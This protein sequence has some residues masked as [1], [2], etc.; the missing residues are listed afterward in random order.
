MYESRNDNVFFS[1]HML[2]RPVHILVWSYAVRY[3]PHHTKPCL[4]AYAD[5]D[6]PDQPAHPHSLIRAFTVRS[7]NHWTL[8]NVSMERKCSDEA[9]CMRE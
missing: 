7:Q 5:S 1:M 4:Q 2:R 6:G 3:E 9:L 8:Q